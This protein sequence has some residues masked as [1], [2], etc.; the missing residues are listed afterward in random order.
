MN[1]RSSCNSKFK[2]QNFFAKV[3]EASRVDSDFICTRFIKKILKMLKYE[4]NGIK[5]I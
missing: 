2:I 3:R 1:F 4:E 5:L